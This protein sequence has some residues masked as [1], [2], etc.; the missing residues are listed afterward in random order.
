MAGETRQGV[1]VVMQAEGTMGTHRVAIITGGSRGAGLDVT[2]Q[3]AG[4]G[5]AVVVNYARDQGAADAAVDQV[6][7]LDDIALAVRAD[8]SDE[9]DVER[10]F[11]ETIEAF[12]GVDV[13]VHAAGQMIDG[14]FG[15]F[16][17]D[18]FD[19]LV[20]TNVRGTFVVNRQASRQ[21]RDGGAIVNFS[22]SV[23]G[24]ARPRFGVYAATKSAVEA[25]TSAL[26]LEL[27]GRDITVN[28]VAPGLDP[29]GTSG[30][31]AQV[32]A[33]LVGTDG[34]GVSGQVIRADRTVSTVD[35]GADQGAHGRDST[36]RGAILEMPPHLRRSP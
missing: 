33:F 24:L 19:A 29:P 22:C 6:L 13:V 7:A 27:R 28:A 34:H 2:L 17:L 12:G 15:D 32:V 26:A 20:R 35:Q 30:D 14:P 31:V 16:D 21:L 36:V 10:L 1:D 25:M 5:Y 11:A 3:L 9:L 18:T 23:V 8:V 4:L